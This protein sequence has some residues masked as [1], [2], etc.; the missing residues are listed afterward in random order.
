MVFNNP[1][2]MKKWVI[3]FC[4]LS[5]AGSVPAGDGQ[6]EE[7]TERFVPY[8]YVVSDQPQKGLA[9]TEA[10]AVFSFA[11]EQG[12]PVLTDIK[13]SFNGEEKTDKAGADNK[14]SL[15]LNPGKYV[16]KFWYDQ[17]HFEVTTDSINMRPGH[18]VQ[19]KVNFHHSKIMMICDKPVIYLYPRQTMNVDV[20][21]EPKGKFMFTYP[22]YKNGWS[23]TANPDGSMESGGKTY[24][25]LF[26]DG[27]VDMSA[28][29]MSGNRNFEVRKGNLVSFFEDKLT[30]MGFN[31]RE[32][33]D[34]ITYW[35]P[36]MNANEVNLIH[37]IFNEEYN[38]YADLQITPKPDHIFRMFMIWQKGGE[39]SDMEHRGQDLPTFKR[40][41]FT[42]VEWGGG[43]IKPVTSK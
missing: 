29:L 11:D 19:I 22:E 32:I 36:R 27:E 1:L 20:K 13:F 5:Q 42:V 9:L 10:L 28:G 34:F 18:R 6:N 23:V 12:K 38:A 17:D 24:N 26:W 4:F 7:G 16:F 15:K 14:V 35:V 25:Y 37:F 39:Q 3:L 33:Q 40:D 8:Y 41:G 43:E 31:S 30:Y 21:L 2:T